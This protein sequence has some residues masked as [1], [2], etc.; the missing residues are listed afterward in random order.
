MHSLHCK[1]ASHL[2]CNFQHFCFQYYKAK[3][4]PQNFMLR[5]T[6]KGETLLSEMPFPA[7]PY[8]LLKKL[9][10]LYIHIVLKTFPWYLVF[11]TRNKIK[12]KEIK[13]VPSNRENITQKAGRYRCSDCD[14]LMQIW[15]CYYSFNIFTNLHSI[16]QRLKLLNKNLIYN[17]NLFLT[18]F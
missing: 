1:Q 5:E 14:I 11:L 15:L 6:C 12:K 4:R 9:I 13:I 7:S 2:N 16:A 18:C 10:Q 8:L 17:V 3:F